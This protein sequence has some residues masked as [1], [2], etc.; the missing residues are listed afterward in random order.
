MDIVGNI[1]EEQYCERQR[2]AA[3]SVGLKFSIPINVDDYPAER[4]NKLWLHLSTQTTM[5]DDFSKG[6][7]PRFI[8][9]WCSPSVFN[10]ELGDMQGWATLHNVFEGSSAEI[11]YAAWNLTVKDAVQ[12]GDEICRFAFTKALVHRITGP[13]PSFN[14]Q[15]QK[16]AT[17][18]G[19][20]FEGELKQAFKFSGKYHGLTLWGLTDDD[21]T[22]RQHVGRQHNYH[23]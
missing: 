1:S 14:K 22:R 7:I 11:H 15:A 9:T 16:L 19:F 20:R 18:M 21:W 2:Q 8:E 3:A 13:I 10:F 5:F 12:A 4:F 6:D 17:L 23:N